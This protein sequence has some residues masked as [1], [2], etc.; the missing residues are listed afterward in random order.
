MAEVVGVSP[1]QVVVIEQS[2]GIPGSTGAP[3]PQGAQG[4]QGVQGAQG[5]QGVPGVQG[6]QGMQGPQGPPG[7]GGE[8]EM[9]YAERVDFASSTVIY[10]GEAAPGASEGAAVWRVR[11][12]V[13]GLDNDVTTTWADGNADFDNVWT[14]RASLGY[15]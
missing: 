12:M 5:A 2:S 11:R 15:S 6:A 13:L 8:E 3:G 10:R 9:K 14:N 1:I 7:S 4:A